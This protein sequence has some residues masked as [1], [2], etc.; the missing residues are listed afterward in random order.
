MAVTLENMSP[1]RRLMITHKVMASL[2][3]W[4]LS[5]DQILAVLDFPEGHRRNDFYHLGVGAGASFGGAVAGAP[6]VDVSVIENT[7]SC[8]LS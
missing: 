7:Q 1:E 3:E 2:D 8:F 6:G 4:G 5:G